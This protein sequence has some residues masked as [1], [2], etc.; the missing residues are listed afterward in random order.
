M[1]DRPFRVLTVCLGNICRSPTAEAA[2]REAAAERRVDLEVRSAGTGDWHV[3]APPNPPMVA[4][5][6]AVG[7]T[8][9]GSGAQVGPDDLAWADL[10]VAMDRHNLADLRRMA[11]LA[12][13]ETPIRRFRE[14]DPDAGGDLDVPDPYGGAADGFAAVVTICRRTAPHV[15]DALTGDG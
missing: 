11:D 12:G 14:F 10:V 9:D 1:P 8:V 3:A 5:A 6:A 7:L 4:A 13:I 15:L 2:L